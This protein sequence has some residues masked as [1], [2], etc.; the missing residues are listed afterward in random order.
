M[1]DVVQLVKDGAGRFEWHYVVSEKNGYRLHVA[2]M[3]DAMKFDAMPELDWHRDREHGSTTMY[4]GVRLPATPAELQT[5]ADMVGGM[6]LTPRVIDLIWLQAGIKFNANVNSGPPHYTIAAE[7]GITDVHK[8]IEADIAKL[9]GDDGNK[10]ISCVGKYWCL[11]NGLGTDGDKKMY[12]TNTACNYGW[13]STETK[14]RGLTQAL[15]A[16]SARGTSTTL[17]TSIQV[18]RFG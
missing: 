10:L 11:I 17:S 12:G 4:D 18:R 1:I 14:K 5:I 7:L 16:G 3:R 13:C 9:G 8:L 15:I 6:L 2:V